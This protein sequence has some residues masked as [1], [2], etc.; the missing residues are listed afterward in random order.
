MLTRICRDSIAERSRKAAKS[1]NKNGLPIRLN[2]KILAVVADL[3]AEGKV[4]VACADGVV[5]GVDL[6][7]RIHP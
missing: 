6:D 5:K 2:S 3:E 4:Y 1:S 7:V